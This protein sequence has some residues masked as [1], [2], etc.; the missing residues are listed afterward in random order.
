MGSMI[1]DPLMCGYVIKGIEVDGIT[2]NTLEDFLKLTNRRMLFI[3][4]FGI[5]QKMLYEYKQ[6][7]KA[8][9]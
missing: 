5:T 7:S 4:P 1:Y 8:Q 9:E 3:P 6:R 2:I